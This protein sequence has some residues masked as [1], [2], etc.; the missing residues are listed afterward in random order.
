MPCKCQGSLN[1]IH[2]RCLSKWVFQTNTSNP[3]QTDPNINIYNSNSIA[4][5][6][7]ETMKYLQFKIK[8]F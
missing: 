6:F 5:Y 4:N 7:D 1:V 3:D 8:H 2:Q